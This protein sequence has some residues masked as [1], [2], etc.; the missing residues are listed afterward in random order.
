MSIRRNLTRQPRRRRR[1]GTSLPSA[2]L[3]TVALLLP[4]AAVAWSSSTTMPPA[5]TFSS[6]VAPRS[7]SSTAADTDAVDETYYSPGLAS[8]TTTMP[9]RPSSNPG[10]TATA[11]APRITMTR[12]LSAKVQDYPELRDMES[13]HLSIQ[14]ACK[15]ISNLIQSSSTAT[16]ASR[17]DA[18]DNSAGSLRDDSMKRLDQIS[19][20]V[21]QNALRF[22]GRLRVVEAPRN[23]GNEDEEGPR[24]HQPG[25]TIA[26]ALDQFGSDGDGTRQKGEGVGGEDGNAWGTTRRLAACF[27]PLDGSGNADAAICTGTVFGVFD[28]DA[29]FRGGET[30][31]LRDASSLSRAVLQPGSK[32][33]AAGY[34]LYSSTTMLVFSLGGGTH[35]FTLDKSINEFVLTHPNMRIPSRGNI[36][37]CNEAYAEGWDGGFKGYLRTLKTG[38]GATGQR[39]T[40]RYIG[41][42]VGDVHRTLMYGGIF[43]CPSDSEVHP[44]GSLQLVYKSAPMAYIIE[45]AGGKASDGNVDLLDVRPNYVHERSPCFMGSPEDMDELVAHLGGDRR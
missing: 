26:Y 38:R 33:L 42:M 25:V 17:G 27:D 10:G 14:M 29:G 19:K 28:A 11:A 12:W 41:S 8:T 24:T 20:N 18:V 40:Q 9:T 35:G 22:T 2:T 13:L 15:T 16:T 6:A 31:D 45:H 34:C 23:T 1:L 39:Y 37:S 44:K 32:L 3:V 7:M 21:L 5:R 30:P 4:S 43:C 36:Y